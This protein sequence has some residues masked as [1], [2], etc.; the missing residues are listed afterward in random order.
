MVIEAHRMR[1]NPSIGP[2]RSLISMM[3]LFDRIVEVLRRWYF[4]P[5][6]KLG[7]VRLAGRRFRGG[8]R[9]RRA[10]NFQN[11]RNETFGNITL[12]MRREQIPDIGRPVIFDSNV[13]DAKLELTS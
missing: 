11:Q 4:G 13:F 12:H 2:K 5:Y 8:E 1:F 7:G 10:S 9:G 6:V 3:I